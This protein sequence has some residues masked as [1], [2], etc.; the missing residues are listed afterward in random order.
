M[1]D[2]NVLAQQDLEGEQAPPPA[3]GVDAA[4][5]QAVRGVVLSALIVAVAAYLFFGGGLNA[6]IGI[7]QRASPAPEVGH[8]APDF[9]LPDLDGTPV[10]L[11]SLRGRPVVVNF[12][13]TWC[14][15]CRAEMPAIQSAYERHRAQGLEVLAV[16]LLEDE[17][18]IRPFLH[19]LDL[20]LPVLLD[21]D[22]AVA[23]DYRVTGLPS[24][25]FIDRDGVIRDIQ[26]GAL[27]E[28]TLQAKLEKIL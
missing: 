9:E 23:R 6:L 1:P 20:T 17:Q 24:T 10:R 18:A 8:P 26:V 7:V 5:F 28:S 14:V 12:W 16:N 25:F 2:E 4:R 3:G 21:R 19:E 22:G 27:L 15:P 11:S 13:A